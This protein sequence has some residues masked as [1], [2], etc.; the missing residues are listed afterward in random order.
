MTAIR[1][2]PV[3]PVVCSYIDGRR[4]EPGPHRLPVINPA[5]EQQVAELAEADAA[6]TARAVEAAQR[7]HL[8]GRWSNLPA[9]SKREVLLRIAQLTGEHLDELAWLETLNSGLPLRYARQFQL[10]RILRNFNFFADTLSQNVERGGLDDDAYL[11]YVLRDPLGVVALI[12][13]WNAPLALAS[14]KIAAA[15]AFGNTCVVKTSEQTPLAVSRFMELLSEAGVPDGVVNMVNGRGSVTGTALVSHPAVRGISF[16]G[17]TE[18]GRAIA[19]VAGPALKRIDLELGGKSANIITESADLD[20]A[21][22]GALAGIYLN[23]GQQCFAG[24]RILLARKIA[25]PFI[26]RF[27]E[28]ARRISVGDPLD[29]DTEVGPL[30]FESHYKRV[31]GFAELAHED[32]N[33]L[34][35]GGRR[36][37][38]FERGYYV[39]PTAVLARSNSARLCQQEIF[40]PFA[41]LLIYDSLDEALAIAND[42]AFGLV[43]YLWTERLEEA[44]RASRALQTGVVLV[45]TNMSLDMRFPFGGYKDSGVGREGIE[46]MR[47]FYSQ[48]KVVTI[49]LRP[50]APLPFGKA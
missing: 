14:T 7:A 23:N 42:S 19:G 44:M 22:D 30:A 45:N 18:T 49:G 3:P 10:P 43:S 40:G 11:R 17:G 38:R 34:L 27:V 15:L 12:S 16:T 4:S 33:T 39:E 24:S 32:G 41:T 50:P 29:P 46:G 20:R 13:P 48:D 2:W 35:T 21:L 1:S 31:L 9:R 6:E 36:A 8:D 26:E 28:R 25:E 5:T 47:H 37:S